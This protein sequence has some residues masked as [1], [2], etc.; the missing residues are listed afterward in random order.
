MAREKSGTGGGAI[1]RVIGSIVFGW[2]KQV[3]PRE[4]SA[5][6]PKFSVAFNNL[7][8]HTSEELSNH[9]SSKSRQT[10]F[11]FKYS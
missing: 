3:K 10:S 5:Q 9:C 8:G 1:L 4:N 7:S 2:R 6:S 11:R